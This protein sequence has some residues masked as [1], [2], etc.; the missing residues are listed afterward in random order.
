[1][2]PLRIHSFLIHKVSRVLL[3][4]LL[5]SS[6]A[7]MDDNNKQ[8]QVAS[9][10][11]Y[12]FPETQEVP[13]LNSNIAQI[14][15]PFRIGIAFVPDNGSP[16]YRLPENKRLQ[17]AGQVGDAFSGYPFVQEIVPVPS[18]YLKPEGGFANLERV[19][20]L[21]SLDVIALISFDQMQNSGAS[22]WSFLYWTG[23]GAYIVEGDKYAIL[24]SVETT[25]FDVKS[26][27]MLMRAGGISTIQG[28]ATL[29][30]FAEHARA[31]R[32][33]GF[34]DAIDEMIKKLHLEVK[35]F[36]EKAVKDPMIK[37]LLP[38]GYDPN[39]KTN[40]PENSTHQ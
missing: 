35:I 14:M 25:V 28:T 9:V 15:V 6:C 12:L 39:E 10:V 33:Q 16:E 19:A 27:R 1:M 31:A 40:Q 2:R 5:L 21:L 38:K 11:S 23:I 20:S 32:T 37:L 29:V 24:T 36:R 13:I 30:G 3:L 26:Q 4:L 18:V 22:G 17:L 8:R 7:A 34:V